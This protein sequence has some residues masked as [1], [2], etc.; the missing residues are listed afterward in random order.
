MAG[1]DNVAWF[2]DH[3][4]AVVYGRALLRAQQYLA[5][6]IPPGARVLIA[7]GGTGWI[8][9][10]M[11]AVHPSGLI[12]VYTE[13]SEKMMAKARRRPC[14]SNTVTFVNAQVEHIPA[15]QHFDVV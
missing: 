13:P 9:E 12:I 8:L 1:Y 14:G 5:D 15:T 4:A 7:G 6:A 10:K 3:L 11:A 2:Y